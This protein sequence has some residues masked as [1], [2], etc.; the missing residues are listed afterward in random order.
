MTAPEEKKWVRSDND[1]WDI[2]T[3]VG[4][5]ALAAATWRALYAASP[6][7]LVR[8]EHARHFVTASADRYLSGLL[9]D[10][11]ASEGASVFPRLDGVQTWFFGEFF[12]SAYGN[13]IGQAVILAAGLDCRAYR[14]EWPANATVYEVDQPKVLDFKARVLAELGA[15]ARVR[16]QAV[17]ADLRN[18]WT[19]PLRAAGFDTDKPTA[20]SVE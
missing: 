4:Y 19:I 16:R 18:D 13:G 20:W 3:S 12:R 17:S 6:E 1:E 10:P 2:V 14:L 11:P 15:D 9:A 5:T 8:D 7:P